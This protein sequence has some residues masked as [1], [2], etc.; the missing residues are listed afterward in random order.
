MKVD[1]RVCG[2]CAGTGEIETLSQGAFI[3]SKERDLAMDFETCYRCMGLGLYPNIRTA[4]RDLS[5][6]RVTLE[7]AMDAAIAALERNWRE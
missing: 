7:D 6:T 1:G 3:L 2:V 4:T 5:D